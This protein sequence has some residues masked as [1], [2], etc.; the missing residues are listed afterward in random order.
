[1]QKSGTDTVVELTDLK[2]TDK[3]TYYII[4][5]ATDESAQCSMA[6]A[7]TTVDKTP[8]L[9]GVVTV[10]VFM[11]SVIR[12]TII[13]LFMCSNYWVFLIFIDTR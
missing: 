2:L 4:V 3:K 13:D 12:P 9:E 11:E 6:I 8:P 7:R 1:M 5:I 10:G